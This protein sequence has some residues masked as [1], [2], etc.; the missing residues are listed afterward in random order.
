MRVISRKALHEFAATHRAAKRPLDDWFNEVRR[1]DWASHHDLKAAH[2]NASIV[3]DCVVFNVGGNKY[4]LVTWINYPAR[5]VLIKGVF[6]HREYD[7]ATLDC[8]PSR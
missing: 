5:L 1:A 3:R 4:R 6:T 2:T 7:D 8:R